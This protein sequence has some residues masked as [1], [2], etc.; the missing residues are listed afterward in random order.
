[1]PMPVRRWRC[2]TFDRKDILFCFYYH[3]LGGSEGLNDLFSD[4]F[5][6]QSN[7]GTEPTT[8]SERENVTI[9]SFGCS[10]LTSYPLEWSV[11]SV[12]LGTRT[13]NNKIKN[14]V[15]V[16]QL[17]KPK[18]TMIYNC[19]WFTCWLAVSDL[20]I[21]VA[22]PRWSWPRSRPADGGRGCPGTMLEDNLQ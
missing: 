20:C 17:W 16:W 8:E 9:I 11:R 5:L 19:D 14:T 3:M 6:L 10:P 21:D 15:S 12:I 2:N 1:M 13:T 22:S 7:Y 18:D 4:G